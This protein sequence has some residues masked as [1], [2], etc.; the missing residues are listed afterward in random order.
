MD[1]AFASGAKGRRFESCQAHQPQVF[2]EVAWLLDRY[3]ML[4]T[5]CDKSKRSQVR[6]L[7][8][9]PTPSFSRGCVVARSVP[10][11]DDR[12]RQ[13]QRVPDHQCLSE[14]SNAGHLLLLRKSWLNAELSVRHPPQSGWLSEWGRLKGGCPGGLGVAL[15]RASVSCA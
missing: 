9:A 6:I 2:Q 5:V 15:E 12:L 7:P 4:T 10:H 3:H 11:V 13:E 8:G 1:R 14:P